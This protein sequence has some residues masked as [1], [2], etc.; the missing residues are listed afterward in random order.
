VSHDLRTPLA[1]ILGL[2]ITL[3][4]DDI[5]LAARESQDL[6]R[7]IAANARKLDRLVTDLLDLDRLSRGI[8]EPQRHPTDVGA[9]VRKV[10]NEGDFLTDH[11]VQ[12]EADPVILAVDGA[13][14]E[15]I[16][17]NLLANAVRHTSIG[18][19]IW[20]KV[21]AVDDGVLIAVEDAGSG[22][23]ADLRE[24][25]FEPFRQGKEG[26]PSP[27]VGIGLSLV[28]RFSELHGGKAWVEDREGGGASFRV[29]LPGAPT[30][31]THFT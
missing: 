18:T 11:P 7:R 31:T 15:R 25:V 20:I 14:V 22:V 26:G 13:K 29:F 10:V 21:N 1:A 27:G 8:L 17:E 2:A 30:G 19:Q 24:A 6:T 3:E 16:V 4:R 5:D 12:V 28:A 23:P 9:L